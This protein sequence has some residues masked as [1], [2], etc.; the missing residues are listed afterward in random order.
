MHESLRA[1]ILLVDDDP[2]FLKVAE[3]NLSKTGAEIV[4]LSNA[5]AALEAFKDNSFDL[6]LSDVKMPGMDGLALLQK[7]RASDPAIPVILITAHGDIEMAVQAMQ[8]GANDFLTKPFKRE[9]LLEKV[10]RALKVRVLESENRAL[11][12]EL[13]D[14]F[15]FRN[16][17]G[18]SPAMRQLFETMSRVAAR[19]TTVLILGESGTGKELVAR[20]LHYSGPRREGRF[21]AVN[22]A[23]IPPA[24][25]A[26]EL[27]G[28]V[29]GAFTGADAPR[30]GRFV[31][32]SG[33]TLFLDEVGDMPLPT[34]I[35][36]LRVLES[37]EI[38]R[39]G[40]NEII[41]VNVRIVSAT[42]RD[43]ETAIA[44][45]TF[46]E[47]LYHRL[48]VVTITLPRL[49]DR[50]ED[51]PLLMEHFIQM[52]ASRHHK[53]IEG[54]TTAARRRLLAN[55]WKGNVREL[56]NIIES[57]VVVDYDGVLDVDDLPP[58]LN[59]RDA[60]PTPNGMGDLH[61]LVGRPLTELERLFVGETLKV[62]AGNREEAAKMLGI[63]ERTLYRKIKEFG[64][65]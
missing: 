50:R 15:S 18:S 3:F 28:H 33:G 5:T 17:V 19:D 27:F 44:A 8:M 21:V 37:G 36:L 12:E 48:K 4:A 7:V 30:E 24:L 59:S 31:A 49:A 38:T 60:E 64:L 54:M 9:I 58:E 55:E 34:Q 13:T 43:L 22:C 6:I 32:A 14:R 11:R 23:A 20:A 41:K 53:Q 51:I 52:H 39:V 63:G 1:K 57:M 16:I 26:S 2:S 35:K 45:G 29:K 47:D 61:E 65:S 46:R 56:K 62:T 25:L 10:G 40:S 42:N